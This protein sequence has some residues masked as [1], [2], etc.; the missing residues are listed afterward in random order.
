MQQLNSNVERDR[1]LIDKKLDDLAKASPS[2]QEVTAYV[3]G[4]SEETAALFDSN[5][6]PASASAKAGDR[7]GPGGEPRQ[8]V[9]TGRD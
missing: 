6:Y 2:A 7:V 3:A 4:T 9:L 8:D 5:Y 1:T